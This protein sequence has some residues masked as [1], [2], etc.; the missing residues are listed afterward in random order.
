MKSFTDI[1]SGSLLLATGVVHNLIG[2]AAGLGLTTG[3][4]GERRPL[5]SE[6]LTLGVQPD[7]LRMA[8][9]WFLFCGFL[10][11]VLGALMRSIERHGHVLPKQLAFQLSCL[12]VVGVALLPQSGI[13][14][15]FPQ[16]WLIYRRAQQ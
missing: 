13:W 7:P 5:L 12:G 3:P 2:F 4:T 14:L 9:F 1:S 8:I 15:V 11:M 6:M 10:M 16:A